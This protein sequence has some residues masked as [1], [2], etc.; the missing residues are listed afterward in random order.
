MHSRDVGKLLEVL[1]YF[2]KEWP[3]AKSPQ[4][5]E[6]RTFQVKHSSRMDTYCALTGHLSK[7]L[8]GNSWHFTDLVHLNQLTKLVSFIRVTKQS[9]LKSV[10][11]LQWSLSRILLKPSISPVRKQ[12]LPQ[13][14]WTC[15]EEFGSSSLEEIVRGISSSLPHTSALPCCPHPN[16]GEHCSTRP[17]GR[18]WESPLLPCL[19]IS[20]VTGGWWT[21][22]SP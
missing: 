3:T 22:M 20:A 1:R 9:V 18:V 5:C 8:K 19:H 17:A 2:I 21:G 6:P 11:L 12:W 16:V 10:C 14:G 4:T 13:L 7:R 15:S